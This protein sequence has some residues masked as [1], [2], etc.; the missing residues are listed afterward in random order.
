MRNKAYNELIA[1]K[2]DHEL[3]LEADVKANSD[4]TESEKTESLSKLNN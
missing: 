4:L 2:T 1:E 3:K